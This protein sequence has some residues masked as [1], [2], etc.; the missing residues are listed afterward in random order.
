M[1]TNSLGRQ[2]GQS[3][4][5]PRLIK[6]IVVINSK[7]RSRSHYS[8]HNQ[9]PLMKLVL[10]LIFVSVFNVQP[11][12]GNLIYELITKLLGKKSIV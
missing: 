10:T 12:D 5:V 2:E 11:G 7:S 3:V 4:I 6:R 1:Q 9:K 8:T